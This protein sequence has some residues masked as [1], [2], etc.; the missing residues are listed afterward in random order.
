MAHA[1]FS[2]ASF[3]LYMSHLWRGPS[4]PAAS[5]RALWNWNWIMKLTKYLQ[6]ER[7]VQFIKQPNSKPCQSGLG[8]LAVI[9]YMSHYNKSLPNQHLIFTLYMECYWV[10]ET[11]LQDQSRQGSLSQVVTGLGV[12][13]YSKTYRKTPITMIYTDDRTIKPQ[14]ALHHRIIKY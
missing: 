13:T 1:S 10:Y 14:Y 8:F 2:P 4:L 7:F 3:D 6:R 9:V 5:H 11:L 12:Y